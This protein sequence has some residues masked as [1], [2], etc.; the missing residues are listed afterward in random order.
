MFRENDVRE[1]F[2]FLIRL[3][4]A[5][6]LLVSASACEGKSSATDIIGYWKDPILFDAPT[7]GFLPDGTF[8]SYDYRGHASFGTYVANQHV[9]TIWRTLPDGT[10][11]MTKRTY[12]ANDDLLTLEAYYPVGDHDGVVGEWRSQSSNTENE[13][14]R[15]VIL[16]SDGS[17][18]RWEMQNGEVTVDLH[19][20]TWKRNE[21]YDDGPAYSVDF[22]RGDVGDY[23][24]YLFI[25]GDVLARPS[26]VLHSVDM[27]PIDAAPP[28]PNADAG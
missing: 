18:D 5:G 21:N 20:G 8:G 26:S 4:I 2:D 7:I 10:E 15:A 17:A 13:L 1:R 16:H 28:N 14:E 22:S 19:D 25:D 23:T 3:A 24:T 12:Y 6:L 11:V 9:V 27:L